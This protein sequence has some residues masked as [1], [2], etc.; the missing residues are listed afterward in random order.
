[1]DRTKSY[2]HYTSVLNFDDVE[3]PMNIGKFERL[4]NVSINIY[5]IEEQKIFLIRLTNDKKKKYVCMY[6]ILEMT[7]WVISRIKNLSRLVSSWT[8]QTEEQEIF[9]RSGSMQ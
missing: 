9:L 2:P 3:F 4:N 7:T 6:K 8:E 5:S 1:V